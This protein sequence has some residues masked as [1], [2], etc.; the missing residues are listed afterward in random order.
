M[1]SH[2]SPSK[3]VS[4]IFQMWFV[5][6]FLNLLKFDIV[7]ADVPLYKR[8]RN[9]ETEAK[10]NKARHPFSNKVSL[11][12]AADF[13]LILSEDTRKQTKNVHSYMQF[14]VMEKKTKNVL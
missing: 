1:F 8:G 2:A 9:S 11:N 10:L 13:Q 5:F 3:R 14:Y 4:A 12:M 7:H 6:F